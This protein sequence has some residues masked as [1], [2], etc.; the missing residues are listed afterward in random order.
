MNT[1][2]TVGKQQ[3]LRITGIT[4]A[5]LQRWGERG[6][7]RPAGAGR[8]PG[9]EL[10]YSWS[11]AVRA[12][13]MHELMDRG[14]TVGSAQRVSVR[15]MADFTAAA[16]DMPMAELVAMIVGGTK[17]IN[18]R[19]Y[20][21]KPQAMVLLRSEAIRDLVQEPGPGYVIALGEIAER[22]RADYFA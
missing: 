7:L 6:I 9:R 5:R 10:R 1:E 19:T 12:R 21:R 13:L 3:F 20:L 2:T 22:I 14:L 8:G 15:A 4:P 16:R 18:G 11:D 17:E